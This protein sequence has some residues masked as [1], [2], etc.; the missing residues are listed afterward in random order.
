DI[1][2]SNLFT[3]VHGNY[4]R[5]SIE[6]AGLDPDNLPQADP[7]KMNFGSGG[8]QEAKA[9]KDIWG[10]GQGIGAVKSIPTAGEL[11]DRL[12]AEYEQAKAELAAKTSLTRGKVLMAAE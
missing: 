8:N 2:Y 3:G 4:L 1:V 11:V 7:S 10:C 5:P 6:R 12:A 9:W